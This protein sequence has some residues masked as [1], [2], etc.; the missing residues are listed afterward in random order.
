MLSDIEIAQQT[1]M[2]RIEGNTYLELALAVLLL[3]ADRGAA[4][5]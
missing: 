5:A 3:D 2:R 4:A 1:Q